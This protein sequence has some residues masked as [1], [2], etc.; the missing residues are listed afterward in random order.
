MRG[1]ITHWSERAHYGFCTDEAGTEYLLRVEDLPISH[2]ALD[3]NARRGLIVEFDAVTVEGTTKP[4]AVN[5]YIILNG[6]CGSEG[7]T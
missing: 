5:V 2:R 3:V 6:R 7:I 1:Q 4:K